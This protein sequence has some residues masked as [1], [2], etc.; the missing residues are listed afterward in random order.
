MRYFVRYLPYSDYINNVCVLVGE[1]REYYKVKST[2]RSACEYMV[3]KSNLMLR[4]SDIQFHELDEDVLI[5]K[6]A[7]QNALNKLSKTKFNKL[8]DNQLE[9]IM[10]ILEEK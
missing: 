7:R 3:R 5:Q 4:G 2:S 1:T 9:R 8:T 6:L 10:K